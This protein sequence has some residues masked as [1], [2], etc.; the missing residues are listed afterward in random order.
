MS[1]DKRWVL[2]LLG[3]LALLTVFLCGGWFIIGYQISQSDARWCSTLELLTSRPVNPPSNVAKN[4]SREADYRLYLDFVQLRRDF[5]CNRGTGR[6][7]SSP[8][9]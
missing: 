7:A 2:A 1:S 8:A 3:L 6:A 4:P 5:G 9:A